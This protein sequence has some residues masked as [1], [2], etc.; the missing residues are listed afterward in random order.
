M[1]FFFASLCITLV[2]MFLTFVS[3]DNQVGNYSQNNGVK[4]KR[5][6]LL[7]EKATRFRVRRHDCEFQLQLSEPPVGGWRW[8]G[9]GKIMLALASYRSC[10]EEQI[11]IIHAKVFP[12]L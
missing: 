11:L 7:G 6:D 8:I 1:H 12:E 2:C 4:W 3:R 5:T 10:C 9:E